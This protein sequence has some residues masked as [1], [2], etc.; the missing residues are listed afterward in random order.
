M[1][2]GTVLDP[3]LMDHR[4]SHLEMECCKLYNGRLM[5]R[6]LLE[7]KNPF[8]FQDLLKKIWKM[9]CFK[10]R[11]FWNPFSGVSV[12]LYQEYMWPLTAVGVP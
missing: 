11:E 5:E 9:L 4:S 8:C 2:C 1:G 7:Q 10:R 12:V 6:Y 3:G